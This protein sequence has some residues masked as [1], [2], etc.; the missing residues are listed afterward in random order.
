[1]PV[2]ARP[3]TR[4]TPDTDA[5]VRARELRVG[6]DLP[7]CAPVDLTVHAGEV[8]AV[9][10]ANGTGKSTLLRTV[11][12]QLEPLGGR[13]EL[14]GAPPDER[15]AQVRSTVAQDLGDDA[16]F[17]ALTVRE[18]LLLTCYGHGVPA[19]GEVVEELVEEFGLVSRADALPSALSSGQRRRLLLA[20][21]LARPRSLLVLDEPEQRL[22][23][24]MRN[25]LT[26]R[27]VEERE[28][29]GAVLLATHDPAV[30]AGAATAVL[31]IGEDQVQPLDPAAG[32]AAIDA[33]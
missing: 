11:V 27:L 20:A 18:H 7:V 4:P 33:L 8:L 13:L 25:H 6:Y 9:I 32:A 21:A 19:P 26:E 16:F 14:L 10:G 29:G 28:A 12:G 1:M 31:L 30:V 17:P 23:A 2:P 15:S 5:L 22:D 3:G 24:G